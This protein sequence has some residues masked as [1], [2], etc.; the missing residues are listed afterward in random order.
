MQRGTDGLEELVMRQSPDDVIP[1]LEA[2]ADPGDATGLFRRWGAVHTAD[3]RMRA[4]TVVSQ[5]NRTLTDL[6]AEVMGRDG[7]VRLDRY[8]GCCGIHKLVRKGHITIEPFDPKLVRVDAIDLRLGNVR[9]VRR[10]GRRILHPV[11]ITTDTYRDM[12]EAVPLSATSPLWLPPGGFA[13]TETLERIKLSKRVG[14]RFDNTSRQARIGLEVV[15]AKHIH[16]GS[17]G[18]TMLEF[19]NRGDDDVVLTPG[20]VVAQ[21]FVYMVDGN[22]AGHGLNGMPMPLGQTTSAAC[23]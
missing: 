9:W 5:R 3:D 7:H 1:W 8:V 12:F 11:E 21:V 23:R 18:A 20:D 15:L 10:R 19:Y 16:A 14:L 4:L 22:H 6:A 17:R 2:Y 13:I